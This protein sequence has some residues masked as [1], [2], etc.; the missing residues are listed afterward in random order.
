V[1]DADSWINRWGQGQRRPDG[2][3]MRPTLFDDQGQPKRAFD[4]VA[5]SLRQARIKFDKKA[6]NN[7]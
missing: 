6:G 7:V 4:A 1:T 2:Q 5:A 3:P